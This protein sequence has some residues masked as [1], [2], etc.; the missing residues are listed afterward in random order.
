[1]QVVKTECFSKAFNSNNPAPTCRN[2]TPSDRSIGVAC[3]CTDEDSCCTAHRYRLLYWATMG[4]TRFTTCRKHIE[5]HSLLRHCTI[6]IDKAI[7]ALHYLA[8]V[9]SEQH[10][11][12]APIGERGD[13]EIEL[14]VAESLRQQQQGGP[15]GL[16]PI[17]LYTSFNLRISL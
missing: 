3:S 9:L 16:L 5:M 13:G 14:Q 11:R 7:H 8:R 17:G 2:I 12:V 15:H 6:A 1:M 4:V 10:P